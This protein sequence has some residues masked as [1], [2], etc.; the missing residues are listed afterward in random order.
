MKNLEIIER[1]E[2]RNSLIDRIDVLDKVKKIVYFGNTDYVTVD[3]STKYYNVPK[4]TMDDLIRRNKDELLLD[5]LRVYKYKEIKDMIKPIGNTKNLDIPSFE[6]PTRG[7]TL[8]PKRALLRIGMLL[9]DSEVAKE[10]RTMLLDNHEQL[11]NIHND[12]KDGKE[13]DI[14]KS[15]PTYFID[16]ENNILEQKKLTIQEIGNALMKGD[17]NEESMLKSRL[18]NLERQLVELEKER[19]DLYADRADK[20]ERYLNSDGLT[21][22]DELSKT[23]SIKKL[24]RNNMYEL[25]RDKKYLKSSGKSKNTPY[26][27]YVENGMFELCVSG[28]YEVDD[29]VYTSYKTYLTSKGVEKIIELVRDLGYD[30]AI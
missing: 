13:I 1:K 29:K 14:D 12:L 18:I 26:Q 24:G 11:T 7:L 16:K 3:L 23:L 21:T 8:I 4:G 22:I 27:K 25:L 17:F 5:G 28:E 9:R 19:V 6:I 30:V 20:F 10:V 15:S 2:V